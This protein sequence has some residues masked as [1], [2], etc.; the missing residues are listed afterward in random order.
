MKTITALLASGFISLS[1]PVLANISNTSSNPVELT[2]PTTSNPDLKKGQLPEATTTDSYEAPTPGEGD[3]STA[4]EA[5]TKA[6][7]DTRPLHRKK[8]TKKTAQNKLGNCDQVRG[9]AL[10]EKTNQMNRAMR[11]KPDRTD[12]REIE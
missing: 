3:L 8:K 7:Q 4:G 12:T 11:E 2:V 9:R 6:G 5:S 10:C 1:M